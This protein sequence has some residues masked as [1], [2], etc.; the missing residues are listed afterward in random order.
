MYWLFG[1]TS[2]TI[3]GFLIGALIGG[4][5]CSVVIHF[6]KGLLAICIL[7]SGLVGE[8]LHYYILSRPR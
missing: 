7:F 5:L 3:P 1:G 2:K 4:A 6:D 8:S